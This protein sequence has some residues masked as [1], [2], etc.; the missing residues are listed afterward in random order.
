MRLSILLLSF[1]LLLV[2]AKTKCLGCKIEFRNLNKHV[3]RC[4]AY[5]ELLAVGLHKRAAATA[6]RLEA[7]QDLKD[8]EWR[9]AQERRRCELEKEA[10]AEVCSFALA[11]SIHDSRVSESRGGVRC[12]C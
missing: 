11:L 9:E 10:A 7:E 1:I 6:R 2:M 3:D 12:A 5:H 4:S 8:A